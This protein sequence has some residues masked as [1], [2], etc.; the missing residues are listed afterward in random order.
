MTCQAILG[1]DETLFP[2]I[3][4]RVTSS[5]EKRKCVSFPADL[6][7]TKGPYRPLIWSGVIFESFIC[8]INNLEPSQYHTWNFGSSNTP[9]P[10]YALIQWGHPEITP[11][12]AP[13]RLLDIPGLQPVPEFM[14][15]CLQG[16]LITLEFYV[17]IL[18]FTGL[19]LKAW[20]YEWGGNLTFQKMFSF[21]GASYLKFWLK[22]TTDDD[23]TPGLPPRSH[24]L[25]DSM[26]VCVKPVSFVCNS[27]KS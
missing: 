20:N 17:V 11:F 2:N 22:S 27:S 14:H 25:A 21:S 10:G 23:L 5:H 15:I 26:G 3:P 7:G 16:D 6:K 13:P 24:R 4:P 18:L 19:K 9:P 1:E 8:F 12:L